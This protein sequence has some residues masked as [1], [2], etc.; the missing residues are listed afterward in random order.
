MQA[1]QVSAGTEGAHQVPCDFCPGTYFEGEGAGGIY[2][3]RSKSPANDSRA[4]HGM[5]GV[6]LGQPGSTDLG[7]SQSLSRGP[8]LPPLW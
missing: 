2:C 5:F 6:L 8:F 1:V 7:S 3:R 4:Q